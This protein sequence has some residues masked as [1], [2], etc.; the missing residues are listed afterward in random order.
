MK[1]LGEV[2]GGKIEYGLGI[3]Q[4]GLGEEKAPIGLNAVNVKEKEGRKFILLQQQ[5]KDVQIKR[6]GGPRKAGSAGRKW[7]Q[8]QRRLDLMSWVLGPPAGV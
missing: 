4:I 3:D 1:C 7:D 6:S 8:S 5:D 2:R